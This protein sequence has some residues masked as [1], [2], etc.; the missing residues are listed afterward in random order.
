MTATD[1]CGIGAG[2]L[3]L[4][5]A[6]GVIL[7]AQLSPD[8]F[9]LPDREMVTVE[10]IFDAVLFV[11]GVPAGSYFLYKGAVSRDDTSEK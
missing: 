2:L 4:G 9:D 1:K 8:L 11:V 3:A 6:G 5:L 10:A 7:L